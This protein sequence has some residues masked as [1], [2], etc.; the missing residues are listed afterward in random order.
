MNKTNSI[1]KWSSNFYL[2]NDDSGTKEK[3]QAEISAS[4][5]LG[6]LFF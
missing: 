5:F 6:K 1:T 4:Y 3:I 2:K